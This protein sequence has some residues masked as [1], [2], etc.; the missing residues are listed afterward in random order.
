MNYKDNIINALT[1]LRDN[2]NIEGGIFQVRAYD[3]VLNNIKKFTGPITKYEQIE[4]IE[5]AGK[6]IKVKLQ[7]IINTGYLVDTEN[8]L[9]KEH[10]DFKSQLL[11]IYGIGPSKAKNL[12]EDHKI[13]SMCELRK[14][15]ELNNDILTSAQKIGLLC[16]EDFLKKIPR[17]EMLMHQKILNLTKKKGEIVGSFRRKEPSSGDI[18][19]M[20][21]IDSIEFGNFTKKLIDNGYIKF[22]LA[23]GEKKMLAVCQIDGK[24][25][26]RIDLIRNSPEEYPFMKMYFT[27][28]KEF[29]VAFRQHCLDRGLSLNEYSF[30]PKVDSLKTEK[31]IFEHVGLKYVDPELRNGKSLF[32]II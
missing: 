14:K 17:K 6:K 1:I 26:R 24:E 30:T 3:K 9:K 4:N 16:Y 13:S 5:G 10:T 12:I 23:K 25:Y 19:V 32:K 29:N 20:L 2:A 21:N 18:D 15:S 22:V 7:E 11:N 8:I 27:G 31:D 28:P